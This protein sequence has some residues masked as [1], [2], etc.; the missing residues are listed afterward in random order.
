[1][2]VPRYWPV[3]PVLLPRLTDGIYDAQRCWQRHLPVRML[4]GIITIDSNNCFRLRKRRAVGS[5]VLKL[6]PVHFGL[7]FVMVLYIARRWRACC[8]QAVRPP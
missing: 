4:A 2:A 7:A 5:D 3:S 6:A 8:I 1:M